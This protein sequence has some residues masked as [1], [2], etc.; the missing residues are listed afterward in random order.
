[1]NNISV[2]NS[3]T[4]K[5]SKITFKEIERDELFNEFLASRTDN[6]TG[7]FTVT[8]PSG[9]L[10][11]REDY[12]IIKSDFNSY[13]VGWSCGDVEINGT[14]Q[15]SRKFTVRYKHKNDVIN[16]NLFQKTFGFFQETRR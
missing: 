15:S 14:T 8:N 9:T 7:K 5:I 11:R 13:L 10:A 1:M 3:T 4:L 6:S 12:Y 2:V 16:K